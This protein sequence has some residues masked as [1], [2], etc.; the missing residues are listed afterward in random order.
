MDANT[1]FF[2]LL[3]IGSLAIFFYFG[4]F[5]ASSKQRDRKDRID[6][7]KSMF[8]RISDSFKKND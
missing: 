4:Q 7:T 1:L 3:I 6:W 8:K 5:R 2:G